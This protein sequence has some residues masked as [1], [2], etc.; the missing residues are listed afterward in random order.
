MGFIFNN[1]NPKAVR[2]SDLE[3][4]ETFR[5]VGHEKIFISIPTV[6]LNL[7]DKPTYNAILTDG[8]M[9][10]FLPEEEVIRVNVECTV[11][12]KED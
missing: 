3:L 10:L 11:F 4:W 12:N 6:Y 9:K 5:E 2:F 1:K 8:G 7:Q